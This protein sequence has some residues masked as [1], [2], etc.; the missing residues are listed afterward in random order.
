MPNMNKVV[1]SH[2]VL[3]MTLDTL[4]FDVAVEE[5]EAGHLPHFA[6]L[7]P[8]GWEERHAPG[9]FTYA[10]HQA[11]FAG[12]LP[13]PKTPGKH[14]R[15]FAL[16]FEG[17]ETTGEETFVFD[18]PD[19]VHGFAQQGYRTICVGGTG[20][21]NKLNPLGNVLPGFFA[22][23]YW[24]TSLGVTDRDSTRNQFQCASEAL[25]AVPTDQRAFLFI[26][27]SALHQ[28][29]CLYL[30]GADEDT[31]ASH[32]AA[33][34]YVDSQ[35]PR[36]LDA[37]QARG[38]AFGIVCSDHGTAYGE[39]GYFGHRVSH[40]VVWTVPYGEFILEARA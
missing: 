3:L 4:R 25:A 10:S 38:P 36:L 17:S 9:N 35:L 19:I 21:F 7:L 32:A 34:R 16:K 2:D 20:F 18:A 30:Y 8:H 22:E 1:G 27:V 23:S 37:L 40:P 5:L 6:E 12:F 24:D 13:T 14:A 15:R 28:P 29:N 26:N 39:D 11:M 33:L 31:I